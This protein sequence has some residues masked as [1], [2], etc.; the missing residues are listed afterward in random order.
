[1]RRKLI[2]LIV[3]LVLAGC[4]SG[5][6]AN[7]DPTT[8][9]APATTPTTP[10]ATTTVSPTTTSTTPTTTT[11]VPEMDV[12]ESTARAVAFSEAYWGSW[13]DIDGA[14]EKFADDVVFYDPADG[15][16]V[17]EGKRVIAPTLSGFVAHFSDVGPVVEEVFVSATGAA[18]RLSLGHGYWPPWSVEPADHPRIIEL[19][20]LHFAG[21]AVT[22]FDIWF[23]DGA[24]GTLGFGC[25]ATSG[26]PNLATIVDRYVT[27][28]TSGDPSQIAALYDGNATFTD[29][30]LRIDAVGPEEISGIAEVRFGQGDVTLE[31][32]EI[33]AQTNGP[34]V[35]TDTDGNVGEVIAVGLHY[36]VSSPSA[37][38]PSYE[39]LA[40]F[41][42]GTRQT[43]GFAPHP[44]GLITREEVFHNPDA[45]AAFIP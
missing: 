23:E 7:D 4:S 11:T 28:W 17:I 35:P 24:L 22:G 43:N 45:L 42:F 40:T 39:S 21:D 6:T 1:M 32:V 26:C 25:F 29:S 13:P 9:T 30:L 8:T 38:F 27:A 18:Y 15:D 34:D 16:F 37:D 12:A 31:V 36:R 44:E 5:D 3:L 41:E 20:E 33:Y 10:S 19:D 14:L 2:L